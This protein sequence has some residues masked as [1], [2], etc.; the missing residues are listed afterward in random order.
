MHNPSLNESPQ[1]VF[2]VQG[3]FTQFAV[4]TLSSDSISA[5]ISATASTESLLNR[6][7]REAIVLA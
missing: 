3:D 5:R 7:P 4:K 6:L 1:S 2:L